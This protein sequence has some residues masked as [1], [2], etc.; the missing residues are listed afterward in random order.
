MNTKAE[1][2][3]SGLDM[4]KWIIVVG[5]FVTGYWGFYY[6]QTN[7]LGSLTTEPLNDPIR[8]LGMLGLFGLGF[9][10][11][12]TTAKGRRFWEFMKSANL[13]LQESGV[14]DWPG[15]PADDLADL[16]CCGHYRYF[17]GDTRLD[18]F[19]GLLAAW[20]GRD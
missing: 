20:L 18:L 3:S 15:N 6:F 1:S 11:A 12:I 16:C 9:F 19:I 8:W 13:E 5:L 2:Q 17:P 7:T 14:A 4:V 10:V